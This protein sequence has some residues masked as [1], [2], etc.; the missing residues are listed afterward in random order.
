M[1]NIYAFTGIFIHIFSYEIF[2]DKCVIFDELSLSTCDV[3][4]LSQIIRR[5]TFLSKFDHSSY[6]KKYAK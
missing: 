2:I 5:L 1:I 4:P 3:L 6:S